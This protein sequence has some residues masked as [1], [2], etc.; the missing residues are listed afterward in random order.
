MRA[1]ISGARTISYLNG[2]TR[3]T[4]D[5]GVV[6]VVVDGGGGWSKHVGAT[7]RIQAV[8]TARRAAAHRSGFMT[9]NT[10]AV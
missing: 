2:C 5:V 3:V 4:A 8:I 9:N 10:T 7:R 1:A 6:G